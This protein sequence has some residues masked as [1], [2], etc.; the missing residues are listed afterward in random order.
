M[1]YTVLNRRFVLQFP[2][3]VETAESHHCLPSTVLG[4]LLYP[5]GIACKDMLGSLGRNGGEVEGV[6]REL[7]V[8]H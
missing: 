7:Y 1:G 3:F 6:V 2:C 5:T 4:P 8:G